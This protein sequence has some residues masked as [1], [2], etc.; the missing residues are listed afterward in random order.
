MP[1]RLEPHESVFVVFRPGREAFDPVISVICDGRSVLSQP[2]AP[3]KL[4][5]KKAVYSVPGDPGKNSRA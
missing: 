4:I 2:P 5:V 1:L 3:S